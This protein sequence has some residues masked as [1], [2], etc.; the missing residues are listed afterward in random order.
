MFMNTFEIED[1]VRRHAGH[2]VLSRAS[3]ILL[4]LS[5]LADACSDGWCYWRKPVLAARKLMELVEYGSKVEPT[6]ENFK[7]ALVPIKAF[8][9]RNA[10]VLRGETVDFN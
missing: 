5:S 9:T 8:L 4:G 3:I 6:R 2:P 7:K 1:A 10:A